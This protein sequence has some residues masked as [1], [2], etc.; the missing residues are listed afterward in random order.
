MR[1][2]LKHRLI[3]WKNDVHFGETKKVFVSES[4]EKKG[5][6]II[7]LEKSL[8]ETLGGKNN[9]VKVS[10]KYLTAGQNDT[11]VDASTDLYTINRI[12]DSL[13]REFD[14]K[15]DQAINERFKDEVV[16]FSEL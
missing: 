8:N 13:D 9:E 5:E 6:L 11:N 16:H 4:P 14:D 3:T 2:D 1:Q 15:H 12:I 10:K 7:K